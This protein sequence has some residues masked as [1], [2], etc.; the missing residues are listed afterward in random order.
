MGSQGICYESVVRSGTR[1]CGVKPHPCRNPL[2]TPPA[3]SAERLH[4]A[5]RKRAQEIHFRSGTIPGRDLE[6]WVQAESEIRLQREK[7]RRRT[8]VVIERN[9]VQYVGE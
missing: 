9:G 2:L 6:N 5:I 4:D 8:T 1:R 7:A 3:M